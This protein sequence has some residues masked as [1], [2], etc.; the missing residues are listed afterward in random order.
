MSVEETIGSTKR[1]ILDAYAVLCYAQDEAGAD[2]VERLLTQAQQ[3][4]VHLFITQLNLGEV[5]YTTIRR[6]GL[7]SADAFLASF[8]ELPVHILEISGELIWSA[9]RIKADHRISLAD[10]FVVAAALQQDATILTG[11]PEFQS[12]Q[13]LVEIQWL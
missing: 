8:S 13:T 3:G 2:H 11:D 9:C 12:V 7:Q 1:I 10:A 5:Y 4:I 6:I